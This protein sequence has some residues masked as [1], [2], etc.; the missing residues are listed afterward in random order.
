MHR[1]D[2]YEPSGMPND[3]QVGNKGTEAETRHL[4]LQPGEAILIRGT[5]RATSMPLLKSTS[6]INALTTDG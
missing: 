1:V 5:P 3:H 4:L 2:G 6:I